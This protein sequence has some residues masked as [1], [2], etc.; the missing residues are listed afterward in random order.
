MVTL[1]MMIKMIIVKTMLSDH[2]D[3]DHKLIIVMIMIIFVM[4]GITLTKTMVI[5]TSM[6]KI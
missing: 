1:M 2:N 3:N 4:K 6:I 5:I